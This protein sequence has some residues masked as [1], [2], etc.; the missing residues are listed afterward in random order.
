MSDATNRLPYCFFSS[1]SGLK[2]PLLFV[3]AL[4][5]LFFSNTSIAQETNSPLSFYGI[6]EINTEGTAINAVSGGLGVA[7]SNGIYINNLNPATLARNRYTVFE[8]GVNMESKAMQNNERRSNTFG[9]ALAPITLAFPMSPKW[10]MSLS[11]R[12]V[13]SITY[14]T[15]SSHK[16]KITGE[17]SIITAYSGSGGLNKAVIS[18]GYKVSK[19]MYI[20][21]ETGLLFGVINKDISTQNLTDSQNYL[22]KL[23]DR[24]N[25]S[26]FQWK[27]GY[28]WRP[29]ISKNYFLNIGATAELSQNVNVTRSIEM[30]TY[31]ASGISKLNADTL[32]R[33]P[34][35]TTTLPSTYRIGVALERPGK[36]N[37]SLDYSM[38]KWNEFKNTEGKNDNL[39][40]SYKVAIGAEYI[41]DFEALNGYFKHVMYRAGA[42]YTQ[43]PYS[44]AN[45]AKLNDMN[46]SVGA[47]FPLRNISYLNLSLVAG[48]RGTLATN[49][50]EEQYTK[51]VVGFTL[52]DFY[53]FRKPKID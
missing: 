51:I 37:V 42:S 13:S 9:G 18:N 24:T 11:L 32:Y 12:P 14:G 29:K 15:F 36:L 44:Y 52:G 39:S 2:T 41:P 47:S 28:L 48:K 3:F 26:G 43:T 7:N 40:N 25:Y 8:M 50:V 16:L 23:A 21:L 35:L 20:G 31:S 33:N 49:G 5:N 38:T 6:G 46:V 34:D 10:S 22:V 4:V 1:F 30:Q 45:G 53:W 27:L 17:D 19:D